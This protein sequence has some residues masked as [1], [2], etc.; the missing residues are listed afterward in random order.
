MDIYKRVLDGIPL[1]IVSNKSASFN[2][3][4]VLR[5]KLWQMTVDTNPDWIIILDADELFENNDLK[6]LRISAEREDIYSYS[7]RFV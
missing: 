7:F 1:T 2:N 5:K 3:E 4:I 6:T